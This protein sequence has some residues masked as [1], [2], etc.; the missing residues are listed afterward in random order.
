VQPSYER[1]TARI[2][3][4]HVLLKI[5][6]LDVI[7]FSETLHYSYYEKSGIGIANQYYND[8]NNMLRALPIMPVTDSEGKYFDYADKKAM[9]LND[10]DALSS[11]PLALMVYARGSNKTKMHNLTPVMSI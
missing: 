4:D 1:T 11:N 9:G 7:K 3:S 10:Y 5:G 6:N 2:N 8:V